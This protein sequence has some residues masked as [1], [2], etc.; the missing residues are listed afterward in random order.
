MSDTHICSGCNSSFTLR[1]YHSHLLQTQDPLCRNV[2]DRLKKS[3]E[4][5]QLLEQV[6]NSSDVVEDVNNQ[7]VDMELDSTVENQ[8]LEE[9]SDDD[10]NRDNDLEIEPEDMY[11]VADLETAWEPP[12][13]GAP[14]EDT[15]SSDEEETYSD[16]GNLPPQRNF[17]RYIIG[18]GYGVKP[19]ARMLYTDKYPSSRAGKPLSR[20]ESRDRSYG[21][22]LGGGDNPWA[23]FHSK[24]D[25]EIAQWAKLRGVG[26]TAFSEV[27]AID[28][29]SFF[30]FFFV[31]SRN[32]HYTK[33]LRGS[34]SIVQ[35]LG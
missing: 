27:L 12:R 1:G 6:A 34:Q 5:Y 13:E 14:Q 8:N 26:S 35:E 11:V 28:G 2:F 29:V 3:Y 31:S 18:D 30:L 16:T 15:S 9:V 25:W 19:A 32:L 17:D 22:S 10:E 21:A 20:E 24:K 23:P 7:D 4:T 33:G